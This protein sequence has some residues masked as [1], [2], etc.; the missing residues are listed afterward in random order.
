[1]GK[2]DNLENWKKNAINELKNQNVDDI[3]VN[4]TEGIIK[5]P[6]YTKVMKILWH[7]LQNAQVTSNKMVH[8]KRHHFLP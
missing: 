6:Q 4:T 3:S 5:K 8:R 1:M 7:I 2:K